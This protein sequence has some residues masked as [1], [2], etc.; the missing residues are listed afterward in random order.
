MLK[1]H[2]REQCLLVVTELVDRHTC[3]HINKEKNLLKLNVHCPKRNHSTKSSSANSP[4]P[5]IINHVR[6]SSSN[7]DRPSPSTVNC[8]KTDNVNIDVTLRHVRVTIVAVE[9]QELLNMMS[10]G[11]CSCLSYP[12][13]KSHLFFVVLYRHLC[14]V[15]I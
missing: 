3:K 2:R 1:V 13:C 6:T 5:V 10:V 9:M 8:S 15:W 4:R 11:L 12:A 7:R 14:P